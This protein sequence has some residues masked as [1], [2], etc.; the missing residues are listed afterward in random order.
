MKKNKAQ[1]QRLTIWNML[2]E[3]C[4]LETK[5]DSIILCESV[6]VNIKIKFENSKTTYG[7]K[8]R[9]DRFKGNS[10]IYFSDF[11]VFTCCPISSLKK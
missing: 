9:N 7:R 4:P 6:E 5:W 3:Q 11:S 8:L 1:D 10:K 2:A